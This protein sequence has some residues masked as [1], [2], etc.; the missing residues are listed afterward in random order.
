MLKSLLMPRKKPKHDKEADQKNLDDRKEPQRDAAVSHRASGEYEDV[1]ASRMRP[2]DDD[3]EE[4]SD[5]D[6][7]ESIDLD[8]TPEGEGPDA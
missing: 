3:A 1:E 5:E 4:L 6:I 7:L 8:A 2:R